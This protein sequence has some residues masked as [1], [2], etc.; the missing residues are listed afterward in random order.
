MNY[1]KS[2]HLKFKRTISNKLLFIIPFITAIFAWIVG[3]FFGFQYTTIYW[4]YAFLLPGAIAILCSL[5]HRKEDSAGK[6]YSV[7]SMPL[8]LSKFE[9]AK[10][11]ILIEKLLVAG[12]F[13]ALL[14]SISN[15][16][17]PVTAVYS[18]PQSMVGSIAIVL[19][20]VW[21]IPLCLYLTR[22][23]GL[24][25]PIILNTILGIFLP[26]LL[27]NT[28]IWWLVPYCWAA[29]LAEPLMGIELNGT[30]AGNPR[31]S[32]IVF[33]SIVLSIFLFVILSFADAKDFSK[34][35]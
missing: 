13:L 16:I 22:K 5:S 15:I 12:I 3:G 25:V 8:N 24:F 11:V 9:M 20:S 26:I 4:W 17:S 7:F 28:A 34:R 1:L 30:F 27:G 31:L 29:K 6:Y 23:T 35:R 14:I 2:E 32:I 21:Q 10:G 19:A 33:I 18:V